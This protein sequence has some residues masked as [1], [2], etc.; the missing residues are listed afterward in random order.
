MEFR[1]VVFWPLV[2]VAERGKCSSFCP[3]SLE[4]SGQ[5]YLLH[6]GYNNSTPKGALHEWHAGL[7]LWSKAAQRLRCADFLLVYKAEIRRQ[8]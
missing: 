2:M 5:E 6:R 7:S 4:N 3:T 1:P 8:E